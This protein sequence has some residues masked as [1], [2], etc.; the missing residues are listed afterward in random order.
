MTHYRDHAATAV[1]FAILAN[2]AV[3]RADIL[4]WDNGQRIPGTEGITLGPGVQLSGQELVRAALSSTNLE[5]ADLTGAN[6]A[7]A[8]LDLS[9]LANANFAGATVHGASF[10]GAGHTGLSREQLYST[11]SYQEKDL[12]G[13]SFSTTVAFYPVGSDLSG[14][15]FNGQDLTGAMF[16]FTMLPEANLEGA[17][18]LG[19]NLSYAT[20]TNADLE[21]AILHSAD[22]SRAN[23]SGANLQSA[24]LSYSSII[25]ANLTRAAMEGAKL[26]NANVNLADTRGSTG[27]DLT[28]ANLSNVIQPDGRITSLRLPTPTA[29]NPHQTLVAYPGV[30]IPIRFDE[31]FSIA[32]G[33]TLNLTDNAA[34]VDYAT[35]NPTAAVRQQIL[36]GRGGP[37]LGA[38]WNGTGI[39]SGTAASSAATQP[40]A[41]SLGY[42]DNATLPLGPYATFHGAPVDESSSLI[43]FTRTGDANLDGVVNDDDV[44]IVNATYAPGVP[45]PHWALG[46]FDYNGFVDDDDV[47]LLNA[48][49]DSSGPP[50]DSLVGP[51]A[52]GAQSP[53]IQVIP[54]PSTTLML[55]VAALLGC[56]VRIDWTGFLSGHRASSA[57]IASADRV[58]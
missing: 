3:A 28:G 58:N 53:A 19:A 50:L 41:S 2:F 46:D 23:L 56:L 9:R 49:Y 5:G 16:V 57:V 25:S 34:I 36:L 44:T 37:G 22:L 45:Q 1:L 14:W 35:F 52:G 38:K 18:L 33:A 13:I 10:A 24:N 51:S 17:N 29:P 20:V 4:R 27:L 21:G 15:D 54:E 12:R 11:A 39:T 26:A 7:N 32:A 55:L 8:K 40:D 43:A 42:A 31:G 30:A 48:F 6:L 47:T